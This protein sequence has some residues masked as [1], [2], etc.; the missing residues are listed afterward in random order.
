MIEYPDPYYHAMS[1]G[2]RGKDIF[3]TDSE[4]ATLVYGLADSFENYDGWIHWLCSNTKHFHPLAQLSYSAGKADG[5]VNI[6]FKVLYETG[7]TVSQCDVIPFHHSYSIDSR[8][9]RPANM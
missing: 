7:T 6:S 5:S 4:R 2:N 3:L 8:V 9:C 1:R